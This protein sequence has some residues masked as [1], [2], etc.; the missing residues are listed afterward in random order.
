MAELLP[1]AQAETI[2]DSLLDYLGTTFALADPDTKQVL[3]A[4]LQSPDT[5]M[6]RGPYIRTRLPFRPAA[7]GWRDSLEWYEGFTPYGHQAAAF[8]R[9]SSYDLGPEKPRP[10]PT[11]VTTGTGSGKTE[12]FLYPVLDHVQ[13]AKRNGQTGTKALILYP[14]NALANDQASR[15]T[16]FLTTYPALGGITAAIY[17]G[18][19]GAKRSRVTKDGL[20]TD[21]EIIRD[22][23]PDILLTNYKMLDQMLLRPSDAAIWKQSATSL[24]YLV[25]DE[26][27]TYDGAQGTDVSMLLRRLGQ[28]LKS[29]WRADEPGI[30]DT[31]R[32]RPLGRITPVATSA[33]LGDGNAPS[34]MLGFAHTVFGDEFTAESVVTESRLTVQEWA[35]GAES[36]VAAAGFTPR[37]ISADTLSAAAVP[38]DPIDAT[39]AVLG[40]LYAKA[41]SAIARATKDD[42]ALLLDLLRAHPLVRELVE[43]TATAV[44]VD[45][46][47]GPGTV[48]GLLTALSHVRATV[49]RS[50]ASVEVHLWIRELTRVDRAVSG[51]P[52]FIWADDGVVVDQ[53]AEDA[54]PAPYLPSVYC[55]H[56]NRSGWGIALAPT[57][58]DL[59]SDDTTIRRRAMNH[60][61]RFRALIHAPQEALDAEAVATPQDGA[62]LAWL[63]VEERRVA[64]Q[65]PSEGDIAEGLAL[66]VLMNM[67]DDAGSESTKDVCPSCRQ[68]EGIRFL[69]SAIATMLSVSLSTLFGTPQLDGREKRALVFTDSVQDAAH[70]A[71]FV[72]ARSH[73]LTLRTL[74]RQALSDG[75]S[76]L[77][78]LTHRVLA[79]AD[80]DQASRYRL[81]PPELAERTDFAKFW[82]AKYA[83]R[84]PPKMRS[85]VTL[86]LLLDT[87]LEL[88]LR[89]G[90]GRTLERTGTALAYVDVPHPKLLSIA[91]E[92]LDSPDVQITLDTLSDGAVHRWVQGVL[93]HMRQR[94]AIGH[95]W[96]VRYR[97]EDGNRWWIT[98][99][100][101]RGQGMPGF[102][103][104]SSAPVFP[105]TGKVKDTDLEPI[106]SP[107][108]WYA[109]WTAK[110]L[111]LTAIEGGTLARLLFERLHHR[112]VLGRITSQSGAHTFDL[113]PTSVVAR[114]VTPAELASDAVSLLCT[115]CRSPLYTSPAVVDL[116]RGAPCLVLR[117]DGTL[118]Q[119]HI[120]DN[121]YRHMY[122]ATDIRRVVA[123][124]HTS[125]LPDEK[126]LEYEDR[127]KMTDPPPDA[128]NVLVATPTL[129]MGIDI[130][131]LS[132]V[133]L[134]SLPRSV[135]SYL[136][137][138]GRA[139]RL[140]GNALALAY[141][142]AR[143]DQLPRFTRPDETINGS[144]RPPATYLDA[145]EILRRQF[146]ASV[147]DIL[148]RR[149]DTPHPR[150]TPD[151]LRSTKPN[152]YLGHLIAEAETRAV[153]LVDEFIAAFP[154]LGDDVVERLRRFPA[155]SDG[156]G[157]S[158]LAQRCHRASFEW[159]KR[160]ELLQ[161][162][163]TAVQQLLP[164][165]QAKAA[166]PASTSEDVAEQR[167]A[168]ATIRLIGKQLSN[169]NAE[170]WISAL[171][172]FGLFP[173]YTL[174][175]DTVTLSV[176]VNWRDPESDEFE[177][178]D[179][180]LG[181]GSAQALRDFAP[182]STFYANGF[183]IQIDAVDL[184][185]ESEDV[186]DWACCARCGYIEDLSQDA[187][188]KA[189]AACPRCASKTIGDAGQ[190]LPVVEM[191][192]VSS[193][194]RREEAAIGDAHDERARQFYT[195]VT[196]AD[197]DPAEI[198]SRWFVDG[199]GL[200]VT[201]VR[202]LQMRWLN[203]GTAMSAG[204]SRL[205]AG[206][207]VESSLFRVC[208]ECGKLDRS[209]RTNRPAEHRPW[210]PLRSEH[211]E[212]AV[213]V[214]LA[215]TM[216]TEG[217][218][219]R[220]PVTITLGDSFAVPSLAAALL[221]GLR[222]RLGGAPDHLHVT[223]IVEPSGEN[224]ERP[225]L[226]LHDTVPGGTGYL[227]DLAGSDAIWDL[228]HR[229]WDVVRHC[230]CG[231]DGKLA[232]DRC[233]LPF[234]ALP[235]IRFTSR[236]AAERH[237]TTLLTGREHGP[238]EPADVPAG[239]PWHVTEVEPVIDDGESDLEKRFRVAFR[240]RLEKL[241]ATISEKPTDRGVV[242][243]IALGP[244]NRWTLQPQENVL[245]SKPDFVLTSARA[246]VPPTAIFTD[247][248]FFHASSTH[249]RVADDAEKR[250]N[251]RDGGYQVIAV[252]R[253]DV[254]GEV[255]QPRT[256]RE[257]AKPKVLK[258]AG[259]GLSASALHLA[260]GNALDLLIAW[261]QEPSHAARKQLAHWLPM[262]AVYSLGAQ[263]TRAENDS[264]VEA[265]L[266]ALTGDVA[267]SSKGDL[268]VGSTTDLALSMRLRSG[269]GGFDVSDVALVLDDA[270]DA[271]SSD[272]KDAWREW[273]HWS[274]L[275]NFRSLGAEVTTRRHVGKTGATGSF[276]TGAYPTTAA[277]PV[278]ELTGPWLEAYESA[279][280]KELVLALAA[281]GVPVPVI[282]DEADGGI[283]LE[284]AWPDVRVAIDIGLS[285]DDRADLA[286]AGWTLTT[287]DIDTVRTTLN[288]K[289]A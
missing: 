35:V 62:G 177:T 20:I 105:V 201:H 99:G 5:G 52:H 167:T 183:E 75:A 260:F 267:A 282:G 243:N 118:Q 114:L 249:N 33:T 221:L 77:D 246:G 161:N 226:L 228:F 187:G 214:A 46:L 83:S 198:N 71:G 211:D 285:D 53:T 138:V 156:P 30:T 216:T 204:N 166:S 206:I 261:V 181:R 254:D 41:P 10:Q 247:G 264:A 67:G 225:A 250:R 234:A 195:V 172:T 76:D 73:A 190:R 12:T 179:F 232:C 144:V 268:V 233:L 180:E 238:D 194:I 186:H 82:T 60:D 200:G 119:H 208:R 127:F 229:A 72:Q 94:G 222:E 193:V 84:I 154:P 253:D 230:D 130:G 262:L 103:R 120:D 257:Q 109:N 100:R 251:L 131:D 280:E 212:D 215:R 95:P 54:F 160:I 48:G 153:E 256:F 135:A 175:D 242:W 39:S 55:R 150:T 141:V 159:I 259:D 237:L 188:K 255:L 182:G 108:G 16:E 42:E 112:D 11:L 3:D 63:M 17:T 158:P 125:L 102:G 22:T 88:G 51:S 27:H 235:D 64:H 287:Q 164:D 271:L 47:G 68:P 197:I 176:S 218:V 286:S 101:K 38:D 80:D 224:T 97:E 107:R 36:R 155:P 223:S 192:N 274:N 1:L 152:T 170:F 209:S 113:P 14:M 270:T 162:R 219:I 23:A 124:E 191:K 273:L 2:K 69:G 19:A 284:I 213:S 34:T 148:A 116:M 58:A 189:P 90:V 61:D 56:C 220:L 104:G 196:A 126:R 110:A 132:A 252:T 25:L 117:C 174:L 66:P 57:G 236:S 8:A 207:D 45:S 289:G 122:A 4:F 92:V 266:E 283:P 18:E 50:A 165:L 85:A 115:T 202:R 89:S 265:A 145:E 248:W 288:E 239:S 142:T 28:T 49:G 263:A 15:L 26:F 245:G 203:M 241:G 147:A 279:M 199:L 137:R 171:E 70:R 134:S 277:S 37:E 121:F 157:T 111:G 21:R 151:A 128:P 31:D 32:A 24:Q 244:H 205:I 140:T 163:L 7:D 178:D 29:Y 272:R 185:L 91:R 240:D 269:A 86:R 169:L 6:F 44:T 231:A 43:R 96:F 136:Q 210:C 278:G 276:T 133:M 9:L 129:E 258:A 106:A 146:T 217:L 93:I 168:E 281:S 139:G 143:G 173:N 184:G 78:A 87:S 98:G 275:L 123:R 79:L 13:R 59:D 40:T 74:I 227:A 65:R 149:P 81:L